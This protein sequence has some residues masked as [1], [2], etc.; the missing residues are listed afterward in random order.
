MVLVVFY[1][2][3]RWVFCS[4]TVLRR[5][6]E[7]VHACHLA[8]FLQRSNSHWSNSN[9][10]ER[11]IQTRKNTFSIPV[12]HVIVRRL[13]RRY[14]ARD[15]HPCWRSHTTR[16]DH[17]WD[18]RLKEPSRPWPSH[19][20][21][22]RWTCAV[23]NRNPTGTVVLRPWGVFRAAS[24]RPEWLKHKWIAAFERMD[25]FGHGRKSEFDYVLCCS[26]QCTTKNFSYKTIVRSPQFGVNKTQCPINKRYFC[27]QFWLESVESRVWGSFTFDYVLAPISALFPCNAFFWPVLP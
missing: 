17:A 14:L 12:S 7:G 20:R 22:K 25:R 27:K 8:F 9:K 13:C 5:T 16:R 4:M 26:K 1:W 23:K 19:Q 6:V 2:V 24:S 18:G 10:T 21:N 15:G 3:R 11:E